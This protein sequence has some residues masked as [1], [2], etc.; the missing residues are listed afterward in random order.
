MGRVSILIVMGATLPIH[1]HGVQTADV[2]GVVVDDKGQPVSNARIILTSPSLQGQRTYTTD[3]SGRFSARLLPPGAYTIQVSEPS[4]QTLSANQ[5]LEL[6]Q[7]YSPRFVLQ[8]VGNAVVSVIGTL[9]QVDKQETSTSSSFRLEEVNNLPT[10]RNVESMMALAPG[11]ID[12]S[13]VNGY[14]Q[15]R[16]ALSS[17]KRFMLDGQEV[18]DSIYGNRGISVIDD[19]ID[20][21]QIIT[22]AISAEYGDVDGGVINAVTKTGGN[23]FTGVFRS[24]LSNA[25]WNATKP[26]TTT[27]NRALIPNKLNHTDSLS[28]GG[29]L[30]KDKLWFFVSGQQRNNSTFQTIDAASSVDPGKGY[31]QGDD[32]KRLQAKFTYQLN[33]D[34]T[35]SFAYVTHREMVTN[36]N[37]L[38]GE[39]AALE[40]QLSQD[41]SWSL[42]WSA[43]WGLNLSMEARVGVKKEALTGGGTVPGVTP[44]FD[45]NSGLAYLN[46]FFNNYDGGDHRDNQSADLKFT[47]LFE[48][49]DS[50]QLVFG[51]NYLKGSHRAQNQQSRTNAY[52]D[53]AG[54]DPLGTLG[55]A[56]DGGTPY[57]YQVYKSS[58][59]TAYDN[60]LGLFINDKWSLNDRVS[61]SL[62]L[63]WDKY[64]AYSEDSPATAGASGLSPRLSG[65]WD[66][67]GDTSWQ[68]AASFSRY[69][70]K[71]LS[72]IVNSVSNAGNPT[73]IGY[74][75]TGPYDGATPGSTASPSSVTN[76]A[77]WTQAY[78]YSSPQTTR[79]SPNL[80][81]PHTNEYQL[82]LTHGFKLVGHDGYVKGT[83]V[84]KEFKDLFDYRAGND[85]TFAPP[86]ELGLGSIY[87]KVWENSSQAK[88][89]YQDMELESG[90]HTPNWDASGNVVWST[91]KGNYQ[92]EG[93]GVGPSGQGLNYFTSINGAP[94]YDINH[95]S[96]SG[97]LVG[98]VP[99]RIRA[100]ADYHFDWSL[101]KTTF[102]I[103]YRFDSGTHDSQTRTVNAADVNPA[104]TQISTLTQYR[105]D[106]RG[107]IVYPSQ[108]FT[109]LAISQD[110]KLFKVSDKS[111]AFFAK[112]AILNV[113]NHQQQ[114]SWRNQWQT[115]N[116]GNIYD[117]AGWTPVTGNGL[118][119]GA[120]D[121]G[122]ARSLTAQAGFK[123]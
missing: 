33:Q 98:H 53:V 12:S 31:A 91:L 72:A 36:N 115:P 58:T 54:W 113:F 120:S 76:P 29:Y 79:L 7:R 78:N 70:A 119:H 15:V 51:G 90:I 48:A 102:G 97:P 49:A 103:I 56:P 8:P 25:S 59:A 87:V 85:G 20:E 77:N 89:T 83:L 75:Y 110:F 24:Q 96:P 45:Y 43:N 21:V 19:A 121:Y 81:A 93:S 2:S 22:G 111:V 118:P 86:A 105:N 13:T 88:R 47:S 44:V 34:H 3:A 122:E 18:S 40:P 62:G 35:L 117:P 16:G 38:S 112:V 42:N 52:Y 95:F 67:F 63:R 57:D 46:G 94:I 100:T 30:I 39:L 6:G 80:K 69:N 109:D 23:K 9:S 114:K 104:L 26:F 64:H 11:V 17:N 106:T 74:L 28:I 55:G 101:G 99:L 60:S 1:A 5:R 108:A 10:N 65:K 68:V 32:D 14:A 50:H 61:L 123:F 82:S 41:S 107:N 37:F 84:R 4:H 27:A 71:P 116:G 66:I 92:G 73:N